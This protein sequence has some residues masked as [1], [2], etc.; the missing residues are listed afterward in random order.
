[1]NIKYLLLFLFLITI[2]GISFSQENRS[3][4][5]SEI[6]KLIEESLVPLENKLIL[7]GKE[8]LYLLS[9]ESKSIQGDYILKILKRNLSGYKILLKPGNTDFTDSV[10]YIIKIA[11]P[12]IIT[13]YKKIFDEDI[14]GTKKVEREISVKY[15]LILEDKKNLYEVFRNKFSNRHKDSFNLDE[16]SLIEDR[17]Y[18]FSRSA[19]PE[20]NTV[21]HLLYPALIIMSTAAA[22][23]LFFTI[24]SN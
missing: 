21:N 10:D 3:S 7:L 1:M 8:K 22:I 6:N 9:D 19:I 15:D 2:R 16:Q 14:I 18:D 20:E 13:L 12:S 5:L 23:I 4:N 24:R 17:N 11:Q